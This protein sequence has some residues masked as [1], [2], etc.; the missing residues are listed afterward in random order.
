M[1][2]LAHSG[3][4]LTPSLPFSHRIA[5]YRAKCA[6]SGAVA[7]LRGYA[8]EELSVQAKERVWNE[9]Q[10]LQVWTGRQGGEGRE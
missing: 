9:V 3:L 6:Y 1:P 5:V 7:V 2:L 4:P 8:R 10:T